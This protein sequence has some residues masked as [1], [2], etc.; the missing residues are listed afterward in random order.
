MKQENSHVTVGLLKCY[1]E[2]FTI[3][4]D[5]IDEFYKDT[6]VV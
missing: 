2:G 5:S 3:S 4:A 6:E 1:T